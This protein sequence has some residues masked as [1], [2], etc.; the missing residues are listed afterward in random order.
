[1]WLNCL[2]E[3]GTFRIAMRQNNCGFESSIIGGL[4]KN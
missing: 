2:G 1:M 4:D 3:N